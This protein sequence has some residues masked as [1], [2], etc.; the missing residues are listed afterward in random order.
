MKWL[1]EER[2][3][4]LLGLMRC[5]LGVLLCIQTWDRVDELLTWGYFGSVF[6]LPL[7]PEA[8]V[9][10]ELVYRLLLGLEGVG[11]LLG[12][13]GWYGREGLFAGS[14]IGIYLMLCDRLQFHNNRFALL[15]CGFLCAFCPS[16]RSFLLYRGKRR[17]LPLAARIAPTLPRRLIQF[18][19]SLL[20]LSSGGGKALDPDWRS[21]QTMLLRFQAGIDEAV[22]AGMRPPHW[23][24]DF[25]TSPFVASLGSKAAISLELGLVVA[26]WFAR[27]RVAALW[28]GAMF[29]VFIQASARVE[30]FS[31]LMGVAY[32]AFV[33]PELRERTLLVDVR[34][35]AGRVTKALVRSLDWLARFRIEELAPE[36]VGGGAVTVVERG[37]A[38]RSGRAVPAALARAL[39]AGFLVW[40]VL[41]LF[42]P[43]RPAVVPAT[44]GAGSEAGHG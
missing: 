13:V 20:Y 33:T 21:G 7:V 8:L 27:T 10:S 4:Y 35:R 19:V 6:H 32:V 15:L 23:F 12:V 5:L 39:P 2:D 36:G 34:T 9:P 26:L 38:R 28:A 31:F 18:Q 25:L 37:G 30:L 40:P 44:T 24:V 1:D 41:A 14:S 3:A 22:Q 11:A 16:D 29:H 17:T 43:R 42:V